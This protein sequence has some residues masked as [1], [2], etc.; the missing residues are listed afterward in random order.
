LA[1]VKNTPEGRKEMMSTL[2]HEVQHAVQDIEG[3]YGGANTG[4]F[5]PAGFAGPKN[6]K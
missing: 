4:M 3:L 2:M 5:Q 6:K 1:N